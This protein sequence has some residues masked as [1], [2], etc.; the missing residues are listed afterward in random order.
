MSSNDF[1]ARLRAEQA[2]DA[3]PSTTFEDVLASVSEVWTRE[4]TSQSRVRKV[5]ESF[6]QYGGAIDVFA[7]HYPEVVSLVWVS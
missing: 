7:Q 2:R 4:P 5:L 1:F 3:Q 6:R